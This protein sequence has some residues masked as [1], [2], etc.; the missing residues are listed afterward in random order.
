MVFARERFD[1]ANPG[2]GFLHRH[3]HLAHVFVLALHR[4]ARAFAEHLNGQNAAWEED[5]CGHGKFPVHVEQD[6]KGED[7]RDRL[8]KGVAAHSGQRRLH[9]DGVV[10]DARHENAGPHLVKKS[11]RLVYHFCKE[12]IANVGHHAVTHPVH[13][14]GITEGHDAAHRHDSRDEQTNPQNRSHRA[15]SV[16][17]F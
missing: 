11:H 17:Q 14:V 2:K 7:N 10:S 8:L 13:V 6:G 15:T 16:E 3:Y 4:F 9:G 5:E 1:H 12:L